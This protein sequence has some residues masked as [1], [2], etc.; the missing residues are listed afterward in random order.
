MGRPWASRGGEDNA[1]FPAA[2]ADLAV[3][4]VGV[5]WRSGQAAA[6]KL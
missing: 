2:K 6:A 3:S 4:Q 1:H 5:A